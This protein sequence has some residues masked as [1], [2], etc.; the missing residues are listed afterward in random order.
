MRRKFALF[1]EVN[2]TSVEQPYPSS[3]GTWIGYGLPLGVPSG[4]P[5]GPPDLLFTPL[6][7]KVCTSLRGAPVR[8]TQK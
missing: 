6:M 5:P 1:V 8:S 2:L 3:M 7:V 4:V